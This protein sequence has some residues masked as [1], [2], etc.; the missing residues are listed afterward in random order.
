[1]A[2]SLKVAMRSPLGRARGTGAAR[3]GIHH[4]VVERIT[5][6]A[7][8]PLTLWFIYVVFHLMG[9]PQ[10]AVAR[11]ASN[12]VNTALA[13]ALIAMTFHHMQL[14]LEV[15]M[16]DYIHDKRAH[17]AAVLVNRAVTG[18]LGLLCAV[19]VLRLAFMG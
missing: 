9:R 1:M 4:W 18:L 8:V 3:S 14:G 2:E 7:L 17:T 10:W 5:A 6:I 19:S 12:P 13:L 15:I 16:G 11:W